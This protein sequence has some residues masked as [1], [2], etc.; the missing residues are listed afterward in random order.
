MQDEG[1]HKPDINLFYNKTKGGMDTMDQMAR[2]FTSKGSTKRWLLSLFY[3]INNIVG[4]NAYSLYLL[5]D[6]E[7]NKAKHKRMRMFLQK[8][9]LELIKLNVKR[10]SQN[11]SGLHKHIVMSMEHVLS[12]NFIKK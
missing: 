6:P 1:K 2:K 8:L 4:I 7:W 10:R 3:I 5:N 12:R 9:G 11:I